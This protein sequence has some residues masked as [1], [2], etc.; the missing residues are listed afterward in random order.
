MP[1][2]YLPVGPKVGQECAQSRLML[3]VKVWPILLPIKARIGT[4]KSTIDGCEAGAPASILDS[5]SGRVGT[6]KS[7]CYYWGTTA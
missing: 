5:P 2:T 4:N 6:E 1:P 3:M 7:A